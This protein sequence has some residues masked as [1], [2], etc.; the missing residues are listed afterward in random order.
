MAT[1]YVTINDMDYEI[2]YTFLENYEEGQFR[3]KITKHDIMSS[4]DYFYDVRE[5]ET[6]Y[7]DLK[8]LYDTAQASN[9]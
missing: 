2:S 6:N 9:L 4:A 7:M 1:V 3:M 8:N 5:S